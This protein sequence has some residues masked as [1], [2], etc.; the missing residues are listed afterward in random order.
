MRTVARTL[1]A[2]LSCCAA[3]ALAQGIAFITDLKGSVSVDGNARVLVLSELAKGQRIV[4]DKDAAASVM[5]IA[6][7]K[8]YSLKGPGEFV[9]KEAELATSTGGPVSARSTEW[10]ASNKVLAQVA[11]TSSASVRMRS[12]APA[13]VDRQP[14]LVFPVEGNVAT[15]QPTFRWIAA[16]PAVES[17]LTLLVAGQEKP[18]HRAKSKGDNYRLATKLKPGTDYVWVVAVGSDEIG[19]GK[20]RTLP[21]DA[22]QLVEKRKPAEK[23]DFSDRV[24]YALLLQEM[25]AT[26]EA[27]ASWA[28]LAQDRADLPELAA[29]A[30]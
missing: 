1:F 16:D 11:K 5:Y 17:Q 24:L 13:K 3:S 14:R 27:R 6:S 25:G 20:F 21:A 9:V 30:K 10:R 23:A 28:S 22:I 2:V 18:V 12:L 7:G 15:L 8:E 19:T 26:Q 29:L 4:V